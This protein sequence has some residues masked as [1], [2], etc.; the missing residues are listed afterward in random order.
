[1]AIRELNP[2]PVTVS[3]Q[4]DPALSCYWRRPKNGTARSEWIVSSQNTPS[5]YMR[6]AKKGVTPLLEYG[7]FT[8]G[9]N[10]RDK[11]GVFWNAAKEPWR[12]IFQMGGAKAFPASQII[13][14][15][16]H[17]MPPYAGVEFPQIDGM[18]IDIIECPEC[19][20]GIFAYARDLGDHLRLGHG[21]NPA[22]LREYGREIGMSFARQRQTRAAR[23]LAEP[24]AEL[25]ELEQQ[26]IPRNKEYACKDCDW[27]PVKGR[28]SSAR[29]LSG[30]RRMKHGVGRKAATGGDS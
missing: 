16:W 28:K 29:A 13:A 6:N 27:A 30:H 20:K 22:E 1:M 4:S 3:G 23:T 7:L 15:R 18:D 5:S 2:T 14:Y 21:W 17:I 19:E 12:L 26:D 8:P 11:N 10:S 25:V 24:I 9:Q